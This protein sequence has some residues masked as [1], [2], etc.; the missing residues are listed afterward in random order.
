MDNN[1]NTSW[2]ILMGQGVGMLIEAWK[3]NIFFSFTFYKGF[4]LTKGLKITK[5]VDIK[6]VSAPAG[7]VLPYKIEVKDKHVLSED[8]KKTQE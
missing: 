3:V 4:G 6:L 2:M 1:E 7:S 5:A 8:E